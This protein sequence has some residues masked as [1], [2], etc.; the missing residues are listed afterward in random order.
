[1]VRDRGTTGSHVSPSKKIGAL[2]KGAKHLMTR[3]TS[4][5]GCGLS[6]ASPVLGGERIA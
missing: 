2:R 5:I 1:M 6:N 3:L 4:G